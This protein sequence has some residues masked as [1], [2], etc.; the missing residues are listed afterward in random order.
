MQVTPAPEPLTFTEQDDGVIH[1]HATQWV[2]RPLEEVFRFFSQ[3]ENL[4]VL[5]PANMQFQMLD[6]TPVGMREGLE[7]HYKLRVKGLPLRWTSRITLWDPPHAFS[8]LQLKGPYTKWDHTH[9]FERDG[10]GTRVID[11]VLYK[12][13]G[14]AWM[15]RLL[16]RPDI[17]KIFSFRQQTLQRLYGGS[18][19]NLG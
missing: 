6:D 7:L 3:P 5:T 11:E 9:R 18:S 10:S 8:D 13:P 12:A 4:Q 14:F 19:T 2:P 16:V 17:R 1:L 15:E